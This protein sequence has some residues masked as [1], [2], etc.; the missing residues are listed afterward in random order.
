[1]RARPAL[2]APAARAGAPRAEREVAF[3]HVFRTARGV[4]VLVARKEG[5]RIV[6]LG[7]YARGGAIEERD[8]EAGL[9]LLMAQTS[10]KGTERRT[11]AEIAAAAET[12]GGSVGASVGGESFGWGISV[13]AANAAAA[14]ALLADVVQHPV[15]PDT[16]FAT[17]RAAAL[18]EL[19]QQR[20]DMYRWPM[21]LATESAFA[22]HPYGRPVGGTEA[23]LTAL[24]AARARAWHRERARAGEL[25]LAVGGDAAHAELDALAAREFDAL[26]MRATAAVASPAWPAEGSSRAETRAKKQTALALLFPGPS[27]TDPERMAA[28]LLAGIASGLGGRFFDELRDRRSLAYTVHAFAAPR[29]L[30]GAFGAY[31]AT[32]PTQEDEARAGLL[33]EFARLRDEPVTAEEL[34]RAQVYALGTHAIARQG[35]GAVLGDMVDAWL[36]GEGLGALATF[37][38]RVRAVTPA[39]IRALAERWFDPARVVEGVIRGTG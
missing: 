18:Q 5:S 15:F 30:A 24:D 3:L 9:T 13:P 38:A 14:A 37:E 39:A 17:E 35:G 8:D 1:P 25:V 7:A 27:R 36:I 26:E 12:L 23:S 32:G 22:G 21:R 28:Q 10:V 19:K 33:A 31:I 11:A 2:P 34:E 16:A 20:D 4:P 6:H 29:R